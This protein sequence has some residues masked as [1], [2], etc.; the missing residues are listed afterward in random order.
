M[1]VHSELKLLVR[2]VSHPYRSRAFVAAK[3]VRLVFFQPASPFNRIHDLQLSRFACEHANQPVAPCLRLVAITAVDERLERYEGTQ[4]RGS[5]RPAIAASGGPVLPKALGFVHQRVGIA[6]AG[7]ATARCVEL[8][9]E[10]DVLTFGDVKSRAQIRGVS[11]ER[12][13]A[14]QRDSVGTDGKGEAIFRA[15]NPR[16]HTAVCKPA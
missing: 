9:E 5:I 4:H 6:S 14:S 12:D 1:P 7:S 10:G 15:A 8:K 16:R 13:I 3:P 11:L 2:L